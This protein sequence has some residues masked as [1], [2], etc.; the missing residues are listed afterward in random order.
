MTL[1]G[2]S[3][4]GSFEHKLMGKQAKAWALCKEKFGTRVYSAPAYGEEDDEHILFSWDR[5]KA[6]REGGPLFCRT[7]GGGTKV[8]EVRMST[9]ISS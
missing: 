8:I 1:A 6:E 4:L 2:C 5:D 9:N 3:D 7:N